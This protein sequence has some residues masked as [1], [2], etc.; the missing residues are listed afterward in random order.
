M[1]FTFAQCVWVGFIIFS[2]VVF[3]VSLWSIF[4]LSDHGEKMDEK[5]LSKERFIA[6]EKNEYSDWTFKSAALPK[7]PCWKCEKCRDSKQMDT[8]PAYKLYKKINIVNPQF[9]ILLIE[10]WQ[11]QVWVPMKKVNALTP[12]HYLH[13]TPEE[14]G[15][16]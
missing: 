15:G 4:L 6:F 11:A 16:N 12:A 8:C 7:L 14:L 3:A 1:D 9:K 10:M 2:A 13:L 5:F